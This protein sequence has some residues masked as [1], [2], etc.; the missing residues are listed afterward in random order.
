MIHQLC[1]SF[2]AR[3]WCRDCRVVR[4]P[5]TLKSKG[6]GFVSYVKKS[7][8]WHFSSLSFL[9]LVCLFSD[10]YFSSVGRSVARSFDWPAGRQMVRQSVPLR[11]RIITDC[12]CYLPRPGVL[13]RARRRAPV[14]LGP[15]LRAGEQGA[16]D[17]APE[18]C[19][20]L[21]ALLSLLLLFSAVLQ[22]P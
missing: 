22:I 3:R 11:T 4:D 12:D 6:Y 1:F 20:P 17:A 8:S 16:P 2:C 18:S 15:I 9:L 19:L 10:R 5:Q 13:W 21:L 14:S 7:V